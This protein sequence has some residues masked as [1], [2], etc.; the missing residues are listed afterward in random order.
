MCTYKLSLTEAFRAFSLSDNRIDSASRMFQHHR[1]A[2][3]SPS[4]RNDLRGNLSVSIP[5]RL[6][7][8][9]S[10]PPFQQILSPRGSLGSSSSTFADSFPNSQEQHRYHPRPYS[11]ASGQGSSQV[12]DKEKK[13]E[14]EDSI[15]QYVNNIPGQTQQLM[16]L[17]QVLL[18]FLFSFLI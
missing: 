7:P 8:D 12:R 13:L 1:S 14:E 18:Q 11:E 10:V 15:Y 4:Q 3:V 5:Q 16:Q 6:S 2:S 9:D 17:H